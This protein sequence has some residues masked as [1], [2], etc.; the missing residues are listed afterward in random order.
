[1]VGEQAKRVAYADI[2]GGRTSR[3]TQAGELGHR[4]KKEH[5]AIAN[6][7]LERL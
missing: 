3:Q 2:L 7:F 6:R 1:M 5:L 4:G